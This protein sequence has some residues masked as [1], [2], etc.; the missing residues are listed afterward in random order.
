MREHTHYS[1]YLTKLKALS[2]QTY[3]LN[4][5][6]QK[7]YVVRTSASCWCFGS[8]HIWFGK[9]LK[10]ME[11]ENMPF[12]T[13]PCVI[14][15]VPCALTNIDS[16]SGRFFSLSEWCFLTCSDTELFYFTR[17]TTLL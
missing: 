4:K 2:L 17:A 8:P 14:M 10:M 13:A 12:E 6:G 16:T 11:K 3:R 15:K 1:P 7:A 5:H 9:L